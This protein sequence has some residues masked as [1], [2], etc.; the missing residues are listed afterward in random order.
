MNAY[1]VFNGENTCI[2]KPCNPCPK[3][4][5]VI[6]SSVTMGENVQVLIIQVIMEFTPELQPQFL[7][8]SI[9]SYLFLYGFGPVVRF[10]HNIKLRSRRAIS[11]LE[12]PYLYAKEI[13]VVISDAVQPVNC[14]PVLLIKGFGNPN[15]G[16]CIKSGAVSN[17][18]SEMVV[19]SLF[20][21]IFNDYTSVGIDVFT[22][23]VPTLA[24]FS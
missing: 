2:V 22:E 3:I 20:Q 10:C 14:S 13:I 5:P 4:A 19:V 11:N 21:L 7:C 18:F 16:V 1:P 23:N 15:C 24:S 6:G 9:T 8:L 12:K 17:N